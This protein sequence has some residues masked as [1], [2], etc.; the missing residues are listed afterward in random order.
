[1]KTVSSG[2]V[3]E[4]TTEEEALAEALTRLRMPR[5]AVTWQVTGE[6]EEMLLPGAKPRV[7]VQVRIRPQYLADKALDHVANM[8]DILGV[9]ATV[10]QDYTDNIIFIRAESQQAAALLI[11]R[12]GQNLDA[13]QHLVT[14]M[15]LP[16]G[17]DA[18]MLVV[19]VENYRQ[20]QFDKLKGLVRRAVERARKSGNEIELDPMPS[21]ERK[22]IHT[23]LRDEPGVKTFSR[24]AEPERS[25]VIIAD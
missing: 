13:L 4:G 12:N 18:P 20:R 23:M 14:R 19:D 24:G 11:G 22:F 5:E 25:L 21:L 3:V 8:L 15:I 16:A 10:T 17:V 2:I 1:M 9:Q 6:D 7:L